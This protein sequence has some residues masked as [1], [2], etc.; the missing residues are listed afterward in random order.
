MKIILAL[1]IFHLTVLP[2]F[3]GDTS[4]DFDGNRGHRHHG[5][6]IDRR[7]DRGPHYLG[8]NSWWADRDGVYDSRPDT[9]YFT[10]RRR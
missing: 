6:Q 4:R 7:I 10:P 3:A 5:S 9:P 8:H 1:L 2:G